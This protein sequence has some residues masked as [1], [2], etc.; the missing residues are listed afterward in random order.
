M[1]ETLYI[2][3]CISNPLRWRTRIDLARVAIADWLKEPNVHVTL[4]ECT[5]GRRPY[6]LADLASERVMH[7]PVRANTLAWTKKIS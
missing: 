5:Y 1:A 6:Q 7:V 3:T 4:V 2:V